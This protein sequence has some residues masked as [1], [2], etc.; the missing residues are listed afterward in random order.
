MRVGRFSER[1]EVGYGI[2]DSDVVHWLAEAPFGVPEPVRGSR[3]DSRL[4]DVDVLV[5]VEPSKVVCV[6]RNFAEHAEQMRL[7]VGVV[8][9]VF[10]KPP[11]ALLAQG[12][13]VEL[14]APS[15]SDHV[16]HEAEM[17]LVIGKEARHVRREEA[18]QYIF[19][20]TAADDVSARDLQRSDP[21]L[22][23]A[24]GFDTFCPLGPYIETEFDIDAELVI[25]CR[26]NGRERQRGTTASL[27]FDLRTMIEHLSSWMTLLPGDV[28]LTGSPGGTARLVP[29]DLVEI[30]VG[31]APPLR[32]GV[33]AS[34][35]P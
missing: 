24:K 1:G 7:A 29:G 14:P 3:P 31:E 9:S 8:P 13:S 21:Q 27:L 4:A 22:T 17:A 5:P 2:V 23:R 28:I 20:Y 33:V 32:H 15:V 26:V 10:F 19:G 6:G 34:S 35:R 25:A 18:A 11:S 16:E 30:S 12:G